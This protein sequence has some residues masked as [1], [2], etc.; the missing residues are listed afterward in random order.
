LSLPSG[1]SPKPAQSARLPRPI[2]HRAAAFRHSLAR[3]GAFCAARLRVVF[4]RSGFPVMQGISSEFGATSRNSCNCV[5]SPGPE[6]GVISVSCESRT[7]EIPCDFMQGILL[8]LQ[9]T[10]YTAAG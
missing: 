5:T 7:A 3:F 4:A 1:N 10:N 2:R 8:G 6:S 9:R